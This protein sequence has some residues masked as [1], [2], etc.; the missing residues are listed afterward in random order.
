MGALVPLEPDHLCSL[1]ALNAGVKRSWGAFVVGVR[2]GVGHSVGMLLF[3]LF[4][5]LVQAHVEWNHWEYLGNY[6]AGL[7]LV[8][9]GTYFFTNESKYV[10]EADDG[11]WAVLQDPSC[12]CCQGQADDRGQGAGPRHQKPPDRVLLCGGPSPFVEAEEKYEDTEASPLLP[13]AHAAGEKPSSSFLG[14]LG[15][16]AIGLVQGICCPSCIAGLAFVGQ[17]GAQRPSYFQIG[18]FFLI[19]FSSVVFFSALTSVAVVAAGQHCSAYCSISNRTTYRAACVL[20][21]VV[22]VTWIVLNAA[23]ILH[24][25]QYTN[26]IEKKLTGMMLGETDIINFPIW[27]QEIITE[28]GPVRVSPGRVW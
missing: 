7:L 26:V 10:K 21:V 6:I 12:F 11:S 2:W 16:A 19:V 24:V 27:L 5:L 3:C 28:I 17:M 8:G 23:G 4:F 1:I 18:L 15:G 13:R 9:I 22:G 14:D 25:V 20:A